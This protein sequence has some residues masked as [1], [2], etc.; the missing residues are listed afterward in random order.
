M[1]KVAGSIKVHNILV[2]MLDVLYVNFHRYHRISNP[3][4]RCMF[5]YPENFVVPLTNN[6]ISIAWTNSSLQLPVA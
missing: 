6:I 3:R 1:G 5:S 4:K 2:I